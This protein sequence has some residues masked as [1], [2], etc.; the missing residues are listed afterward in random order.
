MKR[1]A[2]DRTFFSMFERHQ[3]VMLIIDPDTEAIV[4]ANTAAAAYYGYS[5]KKLRSLPITEINLMPSMLVKSAE[6]QAQSNEVNSFLFQHRFAN[7]EIRDVMVDSSPVTLDGRALLLSIVHDITDQKRMMEAL[8]RRHRQMLSLNRLSEIFLSPRPLDDLYNEIVDEIC[9]ATGFPIA[10][11]A[12]YDEREEKIVIHGRRILPDAPERP[13]VELP[14]DA[15]PSGRVIRTGKPLIEKHLV[16]NPRYTN[17]GLAHTPAQIYIGY[18]MKVGS[19][20]IGCLNVVHSDRIIVDMHTAQ[21]IESLANYV[22][23][24]TARKRQEEELEASREQLRELSKSTQAAIEEERKRISLELHDELGQQLSL[25]MLDLGMIESELKK[26]NKALHGKM[27]S[28]IELADKTVRSVQR[29]SSELRPM[30]LDDLGLGAAVKWAVKEFHKRT[31]IKCEVAINPPHMKAD[32]ERS[33]VIFRILQEALTNVMR[34]S[35]A[36]KVSV[37]L[38]KVDSTIKLKVTDNGIGISKKQIDSAKSIGLTGMRE[39]V[40]PWDGSVVIS[41]TPGKKTEIAA[42]IRTES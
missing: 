15:S 35:K 41:S 27:C 11:I 26:S 1:N 36:T 20:V 31:K 22:A 14:V 2:E 34:H 30:L 23:I 5:R 28:V 18:P 24:L 9:A 4:D 42:S 8:Q 13:L 3:A 12:I 7:G 21:W 38:Q 16:N 29:I 32:Q 19:K 39:R 6:Q 25:L 40:R 33:I 10:G 17:T 37:K